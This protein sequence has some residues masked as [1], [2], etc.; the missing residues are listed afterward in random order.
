MNP[1]EDRVVRA[2]QARSQEADVSQ[3]TLDRNHLALQ[4]RVAD[5][6]RDRRSR[7]LAIAA[8]VV[9]LALA[10]GGVLAWSGGLFDDPAQTTV[11]AGPL[12]AEDRAAALLSDGFHEF[13]RTVTD[14]DHEAAGATEAFARGEV[15]LNV[16]GD[17]LN[18][19]YASGEKARLTVERRA[20]GTWRI[21]PQSENGNICP[22]TGTYRA[23]LTGDRLVL[24]SV[25]DS[26]AAKVAALTG[27]WVR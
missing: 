5:T 16:T 6:R 2:L 22:S 12:P 7:V 3:P 27:T 9:A 24:E 26:C 23:S 13:S 25:R 18:L 14:A 8:G 21:G 20:D 11:P 15:R 1:V 10:I 17:T 19:F 4:R